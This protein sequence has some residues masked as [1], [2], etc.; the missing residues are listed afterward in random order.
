M[1]VRTIAAAATA[2]VVGWLPATSSFASDLCERA[3]LTGMA[4]KYLAALVAHDPSQLPLARVVRFTEN[5][6]ELLLGDGLW[7]TATAAGKYRLYVA[8]PEDG[9]VGLYGTVIEG[10]NPVYMALRLKVDYGL[11]SE[12]E[13]IVVRSGGTTSFPPAGKTM[14]EIF[15]G[16]LDKAVELDAECL[17]SLLLTNTGRSGFVMSSLPKEVQWSPVFAF[18]PGDWNGDGLVDVIAAGNFY[19]VLPYEGRYDAQMPALFAFDPKKQQFEPGPIL[20]GARGEVRDLKWLRTANNGSIL[21]AARNN[22]SLL[23]FHPSPSSR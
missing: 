9:Q 6:Q 23:F 11:I 20:A 22:D 14:E 13:T 19:G 1:R 7:G 16:G 4:D 3:C 8:D 15:G 5:G 18:V 12:V 21:V 10:D 17:S 2:V